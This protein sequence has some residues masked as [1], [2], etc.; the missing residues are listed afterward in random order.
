M[1]SENAPY[2]LS[3]A[4]SIFEG[5]RDYKSLSLIKYSDVDFKNRKIKGYENL[6][7]SEELFNAYRDMHKMKSYK[8]ENREQFFCHN[9]EFLIRRIIANGKDCV[10]NKNVQRNFSMKLKRVGINQSILYDSG[11]ID[12]LL[13]FMGKEHLLKFFFYEEM[14]KAYKT[15]SNRKLEEV[16]KLLNINM[17]VRN[18]LYDYRVYALCLMYD[19]IK[20]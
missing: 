19:V 5:I 18:F 6:I 3:V 1:G 9:D 8:V 11:V 4:L 14:N 10:K 15:E 7:F 16:F 2:Y 20:Y 13:N 17:S 12:K